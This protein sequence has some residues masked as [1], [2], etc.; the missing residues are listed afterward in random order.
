[1]GKD[2][3]SGKYKYQWTTVKGT[4]KA[5][6]KRLAEIL[7][8]IDT[9]SFIKPAKTTLG[10]YLQ[11]WLQDYVKPNLSPRGFE[12][13]ES[14][15]RKYLIPEMGNVILTQ[16]KPEHLQG[17]YTAKLERGLSA[18]SVRYHHA[19]IHKALQTALKWGLVNRNVADAVDAPRA[20]HKEMQ[21]WDE[22]ECCHFLESVKDSP[23]YALFYTALYTG[24]R[25]SEMLGL[26]WHDIDFVFCQLSV[27]R[28]LHQLKDG[29]FAF[30]PPKSASSRRTIALSPSSILSLKEHKEKQALEHAMLAIP[31]KD[32]DLVFGHFEGGPL[33]PNTVTHAWKVLA[34]RSGVKV[35]RLHDARHTHASLM[36]KQGIHPKIVQERLGHASIQ[37]TL[38]TYSH[39][40]PGLQQ[41]AAESFDKLL[42]GRGKNEGVKYY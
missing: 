6:E 17:H 31:S 26:R 33:C 40:V 29:S 28:S 16:L 9:G 3:K 24:M 4:R 39:V 21:I 32:D 36:L 20:R 35:I 12:R 34:T 14:I 38:D 1:M 10:E 8:Q 2:A 19:V 27:K 5:A 23:Y 22:D 42:N 25:R 41:A 11:R 7:H 15:V 37:I 13:Y 30:T 18:G